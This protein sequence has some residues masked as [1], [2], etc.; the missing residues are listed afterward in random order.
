MVTSTSPH[1]YRFRRHR[2]RPTLVIAQALCSPCI[3]KLE[4]KKIIRWPNAG[5]RTPMASLFSCVQTLLSFTL[6]VNSAAEKQTGLFSAVVGAVVVVSVQDL[7]P[8]SQDTSAFYLENIYLLL[9]NPNQTP[10]S[11]AR[12]PPF[13]PPTSAIWVNSCWFLS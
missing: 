4:R 3:Q 6:G 12:P 9:A 8:N 2:Q 13:S 10:S 11:V 7:R 1:Q 5:K